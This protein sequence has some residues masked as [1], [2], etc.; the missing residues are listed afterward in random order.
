M[1]P[2]ETPA[3]KLS[4]RIEASDRM[5]RKSGGLGMRRNRAV[6]SKK[7]RAESGW[8]GGDAWLPIV[9]AFRA[10]P[11]A[12][13]DTIDLQQVQSLASARAPLATQAAASPPHL[14]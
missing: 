1:R 14:L 6:L 12:P 7:L 11:F 2:R 13:S 4:N 3:V 10:F 8:L 9:D 5:L